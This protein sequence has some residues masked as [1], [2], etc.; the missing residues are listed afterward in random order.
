[1]T[2]DVHAHALY[3]HG[4]LDHMHDLG[5]I[6]EPRRDEKF[7]QV[8]RYRGSSEMAHDRIEYVLAVCYH[9]L[10]DQ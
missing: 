7:A 9:T 2:L 6:H 10:V 8:Y 3:L 4:S 1:M 5:T